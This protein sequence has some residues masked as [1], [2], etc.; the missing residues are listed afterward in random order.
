MALRMFK[1]PREEC[2]QDSPEAQV[3]NALRVHY[4]SL[5]SGVPISAPDTQTSTDVYGLR[6]AMIVTHCTSKGVEDG[7]Y[8]ILTIAIGG[9]QKAV[10]EVVDNLKLENLAEDIRK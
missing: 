9:E 2:S 10:K 1:L 8:G 4:G 5:R 7:R 3:S 6:N